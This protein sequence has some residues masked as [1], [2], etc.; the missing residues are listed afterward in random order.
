MGGQT[1]GKRDAQETLRNG[2]N[3]LNDCVG[4]SPSSTSAPF[5]YGGFPGEEAQVGGQTHGK[6]EGTKRMGL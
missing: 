6:R 4:V 3:T 5:G 1:H 2:D